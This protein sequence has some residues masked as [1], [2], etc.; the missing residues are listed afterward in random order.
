MPFVPWIGQGIGCLKH[1]E[2]TSWFSRGNEGNEAENTGGQWANYAF[3]FV[4]VCVF[5][6]VFFCCSWLDDSCVLDKELL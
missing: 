1:F 6:W 3:S 5:W 2:V 4:F